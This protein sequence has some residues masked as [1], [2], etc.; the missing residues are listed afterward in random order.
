MHFF[1]I[2]FIYT[3]TDAVLTSFIF[4]SMSHSL[5]YLTI[6]VSKPLISQLC[7]IYKSDMLPLSA[8]NLQCIEHRRLHLLGVNILQA[9]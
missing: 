6:L 4:L 2:I 1:R 8:W 7:S 9:K 5:K 3:M